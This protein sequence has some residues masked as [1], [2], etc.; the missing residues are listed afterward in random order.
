MHPQQ[1]NYCQSLV[2]LFFSMLSSCLNDVVTKYLAVGLTSYQICFFRFAFGSLFL[3][4][5]MIYHKGIHAFKTKY[6][7]LHFFRGTFLAIGMGLYCYGLTQVEMSTVTVIGFTNPIFILILAR[8]FLK[9][10]VAWPIWLAT[11]CVFIGMSLVFR[12]AVIGY[13]TPVLGCILSTIFFASLDVIN[14]K[15]VAHE[16]I[17]SMLFFSNLMASFCMLPVAGYTWHTP[18]LYQLLVLSILGIGSNLILYFLLKAFQLVDAST[19]APFRY[20]E[21]IFSILFGY[22]FFHEWPAFT[23]WLGA[24]IIISCTCFIAYYQNK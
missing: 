7:V 24:G 17:L 2:W 12:P 10:R 4:P 8:I 21:L 14:K 16:A 6:L 9:E 13:N 19:L 18:T 15:F 1:N 22:L 3:I 11:L 23:T 5:I 20:T